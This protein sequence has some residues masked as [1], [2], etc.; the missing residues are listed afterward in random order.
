MKNVKTL[1][2][3]LL[4]TFSTILFISC[5]SNSNDDSGENASTISS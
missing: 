2:T 1:S 3:I 4:L 5:R